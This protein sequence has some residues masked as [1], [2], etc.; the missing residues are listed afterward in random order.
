MNEGERW[1][2]DSETEEF[3]RMVKQMYSEV[4]YHF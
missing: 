2:T 3:E 4:K 1:E